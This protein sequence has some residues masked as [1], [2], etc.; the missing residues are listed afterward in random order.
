MDKVAVVPT[1]YRI[2]SDMW[3]SL[4]FPRTSDGLRRCNS[5]DEFEY[6]GSTIESVWG[7]VAAVD[8]RSD[9]FRY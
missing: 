1:R 8:D 3:T 9:L 5:I 6:S 2:P 7:G 4:W